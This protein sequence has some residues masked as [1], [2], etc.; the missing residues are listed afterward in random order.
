MKITTPE[1]LIAPVVIAVLVAALA[2]GALAFTLSRHEEA[3]RREELRNLLRSECRLFAERCGQELD[4]IRAKLELKAASTV[5]DAEAIPQT[6]AEE[7]LFAAGFLADRSVTLLYVESGET[8]RRR[9]GK[10]FPSS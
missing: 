7:P 8:W 6:V 5:S 4:V 10:L 9:Y 2:L 1:K 3:F